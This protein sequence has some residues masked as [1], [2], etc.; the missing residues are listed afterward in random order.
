MN[1][2][3]QAAQNK[4]VRWGAVI[5][6]FIA[7]PKLGEG[8]NSVRYVADAVPAAYAGQ[9]EAQKVRSDFDRYIDQRAEEL[10]L[11][12]QRN[13][14]QEEY[15]RKLIDI[16]QQQMPNQMQTLPLPQPSIHRLWDETER[17][18]YC[19]TDTQWWWADGNGYCE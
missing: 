17:R 6:A 18:Y 14:L 13:E 1:I 7:L 5:A 15:N 16:Q 8:W 12:K 11:E 2:L 19:Q 3:Q 4:T 10:K 9:T